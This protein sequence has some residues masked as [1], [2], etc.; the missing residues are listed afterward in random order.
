MPPLTSLSSL[1]SPEG[2]LVER[3]AHADYSC[4]YVVTDA[5]FKN[6]AQEEVSERKGLPGIAILYAPETRNPSLGI[7]LILFS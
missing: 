3:T 7:Y 4:A 6:V 2:V 5:L 1:G